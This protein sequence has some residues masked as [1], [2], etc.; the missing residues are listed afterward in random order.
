MSQRD[1]LACG[2]HLG[3]LFGMKWVRLLVLALALLVVAALIALAGPLRG[4]WEEALRGVVERE[5]GLALHTECTVEGLSVSLF[6]PRADVRGFRLGADG[7]I[8]SLSTARVALL[9]QTSL[10]QARPVLDVEADG[11]VLDLPA[12]LDALPPTQVGPPSPVPRFRLHRVHLADARVRVTDEPEPLVVTAPLVDG[13]LTADGPLGRLRFSARV[14]PV[15]IEHGP[16]AIMLTQVE[17]RGGEGDGG[18]V[19][20]QALV[21]GDGITLDGTERDGALQIAGDLSLAKL[22][23][24]DDALAAL[25]GVAHVEGSLSGA[26]DEPTI[27]VTVHVAALAIAD[28]ALGDVT[29]TARVDRAQVTVSSAQ[30]KGFGGTAEGSGTIQLDEAL[31]STAKVTWKDLGLPELIGPPAGDVPAAALDGEA[32]LKG[33]LTPLAISATA[34]GRIAV[35]GG[36]PPL[37]FKGD[38]RYADGGGG[39]V[40]EVTQGNGN[41]A[42]ANMSVATDGALAGTLRLR[43]ADPDALAGLAKI[44]SL[45]NVR[46]ALET[47]A[48]IAGT[49]RAPRFQ[50]TVDGRDLVVV[51]VRVNSIGGSFAGD[52]SAVRSDGIRAAL[53]GGSLTARGTVALDRVGENTWTVAASGIDGDA[54]GGLVQGI[55]GARL[56]VAGGKFSLDASATGPWPRVRLAG[57][58]HLDDFWLGR[59]RIAQLAA[60]IQAAD[61]R[62]TVDAHMRNRARQEVRVRASGRGDQDLDVALTCDAWSLTSLWQGEEAEMGGTLRARASLR[63]PARFLG[64]TATVAADDLVIGGRAFGSVQLDVTADRGRWRA[65]TNVLDD[66]LRL[67]ADVRPEAGLPFTVD[68]TWT[69]ADVA[70][71]IGAQ[72]GIAVTTSGTLHASG[73]LD[74]VADVDARVDLSTLAITGGA[75]PVAADVPVS[76][77]CRRGLCQLDRLTLRGGTNSLRVSGEVGFDGRVRLALT[78]DGTLSLL[79]LVDPIESA[80]GTFT[81]DATVTH[82]AAGWTALGTLNLDQVAIDAGLPVAVTR[83]AGRLVFDGNLVRV[84]DLRGRIGSGTLRHR[85]LRRPA[86]RTGTD[87]A[88]RGRRRRSVAVA[89]GRSG[90]SRHARGHLGAP[91]R[92]R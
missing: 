18:W 66:T 2:A 5:V 86:Q 22:V 31:D 25:H 70:R 16:R 13:Q 50:G 4:R 77:V 78:G 92:R 64:G 29:A 68:G 8:A 59:E 6:P 80:R 43:V 90:R 19:L 58:A 44:Q 3:A 57:T 17:A 88:A 41:V 73:R 34:S 14:A 85:R 52:P 63:G 24:I 23:V 33:T 54:V 46:G 37:Q 56:P 79:E 55:G 36:A 51:G 84:E 71:L 10:R 65:S 91:A 48:T 47:T 38:G 61:G 30:L 82:G 89:G 53:G 11:V 1:R 35:P 21:R 75:K 32:D 9:P 81:V 42:N 28:R 62:W 72:H 76:I 49:V 45:P 27:D 20:R 67:T 83:S 39:G 40:V 12:L 26:L 74:A 87:L 60:D 69:E 15:T 7:A